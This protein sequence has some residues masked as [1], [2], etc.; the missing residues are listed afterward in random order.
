MKIFEQFDAA[1]IWMR[2][3]LDLNRKRSMEIIRTYINSEIY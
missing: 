1:I 2:N 3:Q